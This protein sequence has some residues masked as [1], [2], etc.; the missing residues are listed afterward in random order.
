MN[1]SRPV[2][3]RPG[4]PRLDAL[5]A[6]HDGFFIRLGLIDIAGDLA[7]GAL[8]SQLVYW[9]PRL[10]IERDGHLWLAKTRSDWWDECRLTEM[11]V[12]RAI[13][14][15]EGRGLIVKAIWKWRDAPTTHLRLVPE[16]IE[17]ELSNLPPPGGDHSIRVKHPEPDPVETPGRFRDHHPNPSGA[18]AHID[19]GETPDSSSLHTE[20]TYRDYKQASAAADDGVRV[21]ESLSLQRPEVPTLF[22]LEA[23]PRRMNEEVR[24]VFE[25]WVRVTKRT[26]RTMLDDKRKALIGAAL[27]DYPLEDCLDAVRGW[28]RSEFHCGENPAQRVH[29]DLQLLL[30][31]AAHLERFRDLERAGPAARRP[32][33]TNPSNGTI[34][35]F[36]RAGEVAF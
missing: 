12:R 19:L 20:T 5:L 6:T 24:T 27:G 18:D 32:A 34:G 4:T 16:V 33:T 2:A 35:T 25:E 21:E 14:Q 11:Q 29:N 1:R 3:A 17:A 31:D 23:V 26:G 9:H 28:R 15:L 10:T 13:S 30:R 22:G 8:L 36:D 7:S